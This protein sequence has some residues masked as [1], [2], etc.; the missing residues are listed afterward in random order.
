MS[1][2]DE[3]LQRPAD[4]QA[5]YFV[6]SLYNWSENAMG[7]IFPDF[8]VSF[9]GHNFLTSFPMNLFDHSNQSYDSTFQ[10][11][12]LPGYTFCAIFF[13]NSISVVNFCDFRNFK[14]ICQKKKKSRNI[15]FHGPIIHQTKAD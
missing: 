5:I 13:K 11:K 6:L 1:E 2:S 15:A 10:L 12:Y 7:V 9:N 14:I 4:R 3:C 8:R